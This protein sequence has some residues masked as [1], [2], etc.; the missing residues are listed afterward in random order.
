MRSE[1]L[2]LRDIVDAADAIAGFVAFRNIIVHSYFATDPT[3]VWYAA[4]RNAPD[5]RQQIKVI[6]T[7][8]FPDS[9]PD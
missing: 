8:E 5:L 7:S 1:A 9:L 4:I 6:L 3:I 2:Y